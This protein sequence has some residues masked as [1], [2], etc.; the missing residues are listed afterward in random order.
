MPK[1]TTD[2]FIAKARAIHGD[3]YDYS[4]VEYVNS[5]TH[6]IIICPIHGEFLQ[7]PDKHLLGQGCPRCSGLVKLTT[8]EF[9]QRAKEIHGNKYD[10]SKV[11]YINS[12]TDVCI[13]CKEHGEFFQKPVSHFK[14]HGCRK[15]AGTFPLT[16]E[17]FIQK[18]NDVHNNKY[19]YSLVDIINTKTKVCIICPEHREFLQTPCDHLAGH[20]CPKCGNVYN[21]TTEEF[22]E[23]AIKIH[24]NKY[25]YS[26]VNYVN[27][28]TNVCIIC[29]EHGEFWQ[30]PG[31]H[32]NGQGCPFCAGHIQYSTE[33]FIEKAKEVHGNRYDYSKVQY[34]NYKTKVC[35]ICK[36]HGEFWQAPD[37]HLHGQGC[38]EC[39]GRRQ[40]TT[41][42]FI[43]AAKL[44][45]GD[46]YD[47]SK[48][49][50]SNL[51]SK[52]CIVCLKHGEF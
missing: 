34:I 46:L 2:E 27:K 4:K 5:K 37:N 26:K 25:D 16:N 43:V 52:V 40:K 15:C 24:G 32:L 18:A 28:R 41:E 29:P 35:I 6:V 42:E 13:I 10:Y 8:D 31:G 30:T 11:N 51:R 49:E 17:E 38:I 50:Y 7:R 22:V 45:H 14:G 21:P 36:E 47:Y 20:G 19:D 39:S 3:K 1:V 12:Q 9:I 33:S 48:V 23:R 44:M